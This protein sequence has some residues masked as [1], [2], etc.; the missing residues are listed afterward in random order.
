MAEELL[1][2]MAQ[3][4][5]AALG[6]G[7]AVYLDAVPQGAAAPCVFLQILHEERIPFP[8]GR[9]QALLRAEALYLPAP[10]QREDRPALLAALDRLEAALE[11]F[12]LP[13][14][15][16]RA[17]SLRGELRQ[18]GAAALAEYA[19]FRRREKA[20]EPME[21]ARVSL[22]LREEENHESL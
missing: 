7:T 11:A 17:R 5:G 6:E 4:V 8:N 3:A 1:R 21:E 13:G 15:W 10:A 19:L 20:G 16:A 2:A 9:Q 12:P 22:A 14:G 18:E